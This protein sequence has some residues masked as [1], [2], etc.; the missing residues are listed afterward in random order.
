[1]GGGLSHCP[2]RSPLGRRDDLSVKMEPILEDLR[3]EYTWHVPEIDTRPLD[4]EQGS[5][6]E[7]KQEMRPEKQAGQI[8]SGQGG[9][10]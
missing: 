1:M 4:L 3:Q 8:M 2:C 7:E 6:R 5:R 9:D 10:G